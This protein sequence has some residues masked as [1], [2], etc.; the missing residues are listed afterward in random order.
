MA[1]HFWFAGL[2]N[3]SHCYLLDEREASQQS[4]AESCRGEES[5][6]AGTQGGV[7]YSHNPALWKSASEVPDHGKLRWGARSETG[8]SD[9]YLRRGGQSEHGLSLVADFERDH[10]ILQR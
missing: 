1:P 2:G 8:N 7:V 4:G 9:R 6:M 3:G 5:R 10:D